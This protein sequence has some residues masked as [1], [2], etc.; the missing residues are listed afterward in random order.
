MEILKLIGAVKFSFQTILAS[1]T[2]CLGALS[3]TSLANR[4]Y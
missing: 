1:Y 4:V 2:L 3:L